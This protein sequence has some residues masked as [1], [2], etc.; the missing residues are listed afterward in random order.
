MNACAL[1]RAR[2]GLD[3]RESGSIRVEEGGQE[4]AERAIDVARGTCFG[5]T[6]SVRVGGYQPRDDRLERGA[7]GAVSV[8]NGSR[9]AC[10][11]ASIGTAAAAPA[12][13]TRLSTSRRETR[14]DQLEW[15]AM[16]GPPEDRTQHSALLDGDLE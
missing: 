16:L 2:V 4:S 1:R 12:T 6:R 15:S 11:I 10:A 3:A 7:L 13:P 5:G 9:V 8:S 14:P